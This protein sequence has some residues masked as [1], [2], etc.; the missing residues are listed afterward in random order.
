MGCVLRYIEKPRPMSAST[1]PTKKN[2][3]KNMG[4]VLKDIE[5]PRSMSA[6]TKPTNKFI[7]KKKHELCLKR[8]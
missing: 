6:S 8:F 7:F 4:C 1:K 5:E 2:N 3:Y